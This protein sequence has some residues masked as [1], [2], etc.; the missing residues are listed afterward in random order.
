[1]QRQRSEPREQSVL[2]VEDE[3]LVR[4]EL[5]DYLRGCGH[6]VIEASSTDEAATV[7][8]NVPDEVSLVLCSANAAGAITAFEL[9]QQVRSGH[10][11]IPVLLAGTV[12]K[13][14]AAAGEL[15][16]EG[17]ELARPYDPAVVVDR[18]KRSLAERDR[19]GGGAR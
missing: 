15:C 11:E 6:R 4:R 14:A 1:M 17:P 16:E 12:E 13:A 2:L 18:I 10:P 7:L 5:A 19:A 3:V 9:A 8:S